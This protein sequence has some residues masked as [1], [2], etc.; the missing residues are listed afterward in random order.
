MNAQKIALLTDSCA[1]IP[2][3]LCERYGI[4]VLPLR[5][6]F[7]DGEYLDGQTITAD[8]LYAR[9]PRELP[10]TSLPSGE[11]VEAVF[12]RIAADGYEKVLA[13]HLSAGL[14]GT[15]NLVRLLGGERTDLE[16]R[17]F[18]SVS[19]S[20]GIGLVLIQAARLIEQGCDWDSLLGLVP[21][22][23]AGTKVFFCV[24]TLEYLQKGGRIGRISAIAG[25]L[26]QV[27]PIITFAESGELVNIS[28]G[29]GRRAALDKLAALFREALPAGQRVIAAVVD[30]G[31]PAEGEALRAQIE[32]LLPPGTEVLRGQIDCTLGTY[33]GPHLLGAG[34]QTVPD[35]PAGT[36][37]T[38][39]DFF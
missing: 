33:V 25:T 15:Y 14:S 7:G 21:G 6:L 22:M 29:R 1:D 35:W 32:P 13:V 28:K 5:L 10:V 9:L 37:S 38:E 23:I 39:N 27:K 30:G 16:V 36:P 12:S 4:Y 20:L 26:L 34:F 3:A 2:P 31:A 18:D 17:A 24:D 11:Q 8:G 19:G